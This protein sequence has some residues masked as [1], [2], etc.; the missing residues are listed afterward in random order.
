M[1][2]IP[3]PNNNLMNIFNQGMTPNGLVLPD[4]LNYEE[5]EEIFKYVCNV[6]KNAQWILGD[7]L[8]HVKRV[9]GETYAELLEKTKYALGTLKNFKYVS[10]KVHPS[11]RHDQL[12]PEH[13]R[14]V[15]PFEPKKQKEWLDKAEAGNM[16]VKQLRHAIRE[17]KQ[18]EQA[19][20]PDPAP[21]NPE[22][23][24]GN[25]T[26]EKFDI[27]YADPPW[28]KAI[29]IKADPSKGMDLKALCSY[30]TQGYCHDDAIL[31]LWSSI[32][33]LAD[34]LNIME[35]WG[36]EYIRNLVWFKTTLDMDDWIKPQ[37]ELLLIGTKGNFQKPE[38]DNRQDSVFQGNQVEN[39]DRPDIVYQLIESMYPDSTRT[40]L[41]GDNNREGWGKQ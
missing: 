2:I 16:N 33:R 35:A 20:P 8:N 10:A 26:F 37:H 3:I 17:E 7:I 4:N 5:C 30:P 11:C 27:V 32:P 21:A 25:L 24:T 12:S 40:E 6:E 22:A 41:F 34:S 38:L 18:S 36:F 31:F 14:H 9:H 15:A 28:E 39:Q 19:P 13:H 1:Q 29:S 23:T